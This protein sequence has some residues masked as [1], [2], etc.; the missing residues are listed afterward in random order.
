MLK[1]IFD[2]CL[3]YKKL[4]YDQSIS[5]TE[6]NEQERKMRQMEL[7]HEYRM[8]QL[9]SKGNDNCKYIID[10]SIPPANV[11]EEQTKYLN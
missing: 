1:M 5:K 2:F 4:K 3:K 10:S 7:D 11:A 8:K 9:E 6:A